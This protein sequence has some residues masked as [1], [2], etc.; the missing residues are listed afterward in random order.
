MLS[1]LVGRNSFLDSTPRHF[2]TSMEVAL[3][4][5]VK[6]TQQLTTKPCFAPHH[7]NQLL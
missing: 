3:Q 2:A 6:S 1:E 4:L 5:V 7:C